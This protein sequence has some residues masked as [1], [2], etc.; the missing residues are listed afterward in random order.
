MTESPRTQ[1]MVD[2]APFYYQQSVVYKDIQNAIA[3][4]L[5]ISDKNNKD[6]RLQLSIKTATWGLK[7]WE[8]G[9]GIPTILS[10]DYEIRRSRV[11]SKWR[12]FGNFSGSLIKSVAEA[13][14]G[15][16]V[17]VSIDIPEHL[18]IITF[19]GKLGIPPNIEDLKA[20]IDNIIH[21]HLGV[22]Y[23]F[24][25]VI[26]DRLKEKYATYNDLAAS[27]LTYDEILVT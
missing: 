15:G 24:T 12:G 5:D 6:L 21:A 17:E 23:V 11:L 16:E 7:Y 26:Y 9:L 3:S 2:S 27:G 25:Y 13:Y 20:Q 22:E 14:S 1:S 8:E 19:V 18:V 4:E 10:D